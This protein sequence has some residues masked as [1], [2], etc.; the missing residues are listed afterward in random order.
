MAIDFGL[1]RPLTEGVHL[2]EVAKIAPTPSGIDSLASGLQQGISTA[3]S[4]Q[5]SAVERQKA[6]VDIQQTQQNMAQ[7]A[8]KAPS[9]LQNSQ[10][11]ADFNTARAQGAQ[12]DLQAAQ[13]K[14]AADAR[15][16]AAYQQGGMAGARAAEYE[17]G[18][19]DAGQK[20][21]TANLAIQKSISEVAKSNADTDTVVLKNAKAIT[22]QLG[23]VAST[24]SNIEDPQTQIK[25]AGLLLSTLPQSAQKVFAGIP[26]TPAGY[27]PQYLHAVIANSLQQKQDDAN[28][29]N[30]KDAGKLQP[31]TTPLGMAQNLVEQRQN[32]LTAAKQSGDAT[33]IQQAQQ[34]YN[35]AND[36][37]SKILTP[38]SLSGGGGTQKAI[39]SKDADEMKTADLAMPGLKT[40]ETNSNSVLNI[41]KVVPKG[42]VGKLQDLTKLNINSTQVQILQHFFAESGFVA[43]SA[44]ANQTPGEKMTQSQL[45]QL[46]KIVGGTNINWDSIKAIV[47][48]VRD[49]AQTKAHD[50]WVTSNRI[51]AGGDQQK[52]QTWRTAVPEPFDPQKANE[53]SGYVHNGRPVPNAALHQAMLDHPDMTEDKLVAAFG[54]QKASK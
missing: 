1:L 41:L 21:D 29:A 3:N 53:P 37:T 40:L 42:T 25:T 32:E 9:E 48:N 46:N 7:S 12:M 11:T 28:D 15:V 43:K 23:T 14:D 50:N 30:A 6:Q 27:D 16:N 24:L 19:V 39:D 2:G 33:R 34:N 35:Q 10:A 54:L 31:K 5:N 44:L 26:V 36:A 45:D 18:G 52:Y 47:G 49:Q 13:A 51:R 4:I 22:D 20:F 17:Y 8:A 38:N